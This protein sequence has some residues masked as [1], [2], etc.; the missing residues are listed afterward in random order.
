MTLTLEIEAMSQIQHA[1]ATSNQPRLRQLIAVEADDQIHVYG[2]VPTF[3][4]KAMA[5]E[6]IKLAAGDRRF[7]LNIAVDN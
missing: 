5:I 4:L 3:Y 6:T 2:C 1:L 7:R